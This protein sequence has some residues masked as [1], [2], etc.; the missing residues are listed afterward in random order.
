MSNNGKNLSV[1]AE[2]SYRNGLI[3]YIKASGINFENIDKISTPELKQ[4]ALNIYSLESEY[5]QTINM[6]SEFGEKINLLTVL[7]KD[8]QVIVHTRV[9]NKGKIGKVFRGK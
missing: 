4:Y 7:D 2:R 1:E 6:V 3:E 5:Q 9:P 8:E